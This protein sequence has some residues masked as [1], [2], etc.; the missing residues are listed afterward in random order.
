MQTTS[1]A[2]AQNADAHDEQSERVIDLPEALGGAWTC[3]SGSRLIAKDALKGMLRLGARSV[4]DLISSTPPYRW[5]LRGAQPDP[6]IIGALDP[7]PGRV[8]I[9]NQLF[10][11]VWALAGSTIRTGGSAPWKVDFPSDAFAEELHGFSWLRHFRAAPGETAQALSRAL[12]SGWIETY[13]G[14]ETIA[15]RP[16]VA[17]RRIQSWLSNSKLMWDGADVIWRCTVTRQIAE[18]SRHLANSLALVPEGAPRI[19]VAVGLALSGIC[20]SEGGARAARGLSLLAQDLDRQLLPDGGHVSRN[21]ATLVQ[22]FADLVS[23]Q[24]TLESAR[25]ATPEFLRRALDRIAPMIRML[26]HGDGRLAL[27]NGGDEGAEAFLDALLARSGQSGG[28]L[29]HARH[30][31]Y[32]R[33]EAGKTIII[34]DTGAVPAGG[35]SIDTHGGPLA[36]EL[37]S[38][39][40]RIV[41]NC[42]PAVG[43]GLEWRK[44]AR[45]TA[46]HST[47]SI[48]DQPALRILDTGLSAKLLGPRVLGG[49]RCTKSAAGDSEQGRWLW[50]TQDAYVEAFGLVHE[51]RLF[52]DAQG[53]DMRGEDRLSADPRADTPSEPVVFAVRFHLHPDIRASLARDGKSVLILLPNGDGWRFRATGGTLALEDSIYLGRMETAR[54]T[55]QIVI[56]G[57]T[58]PQAEAQAIVKWAFQNL[59]Q[60]KSAPTAAE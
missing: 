59:V 47:L 51:R 3:R 12:V 18:Q 52:L 22:I 25:H 1:H 19:V 21:P 17:A 40:H 35:Q 55:E 60:N 31:G 11:G 26:R 37:S 34:V 43:R 14:Y 42:G 8:A 7:R 2:Y 4:L 38:G 29:A 9:A 46:A 30:A 50:A 36:V 58:A 41:V 10:T 39:A 33:L 24:A 27:F 13:G 32:H 28:A 6:D 56:R 49:L 16:A 53:R 48:G 5:A 15:W 57:T 54:K 23:L 20:L 45:G 44:A